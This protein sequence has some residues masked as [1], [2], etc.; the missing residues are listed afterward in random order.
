M[1]ILFV[2]HACHLKTKSADFFLD[3]LRREHTVETHYYEK[4]Y[5]C[6]IPKE[7]IAAA[8]LVVFW[9]FLPGR[10]H[11]AIPGKPCLFV[12]MYDNEWGSKWQWR[13]IAKS[14][15]SVLSF[16]DAVTRHAMSCGVKNILTVHY[17]LDPDLFKAGVGD[18][19]QAVY[20][21]RGN[22]S[23]GQIRALF[24]PDAIDRL[25]V[26]RD[27]LPADRYD[28]FISR[29]GVYVAPRRKEGIG[30]AFLEQLARGKCVV[31]H[32]DATMNEYIQDG[33]NGILRDFDCPCRPVMAADIANVLPR[34]RRKAEQSY[35]RWAQERSSILPFVDRISKC[36]A[37]TSW[38]I[39][40]MIV[41]YLLEYAVKR[42]R[43]SGI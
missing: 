40:F 16:C 18:A 35:E 7:K 6:N 3:I 9:E 28:D 20:W 38:A 41:P 13:R 25:T 8:D 19:R 24:A 37:T 12:P 32:D 42:L 5:R 34:V 4:C 26:Q 31:A 15:M 22:F 17:A 2:D 39:W 14:G 27:F 30:M 36:A 1:N 29:F 10:Y 21:D 11:I 23:E 43:R 33:V